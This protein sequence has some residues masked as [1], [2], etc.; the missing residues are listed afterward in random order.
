MNAEHAAALARVWPEVAARLAGML[1][2]RGVDRATAEDIVQ[3]TALR[4]L[5]TSVHFTDAEDLL[6]W[7][8][9]VGFRLARD[10]KL[11]ASR[12]EVVPSPE[13]PS[14]VTVDHEV[15]Q[16]LRLEAAIRGLE[17]LSPLDRDAILSAVTGFTPSSRQESMRLAVRR[18]RAR[19]RLVALMKT[20]LAALLG[21]LGLR[22]PGLKLGRAAL[23]GAAGVP[24]VVTV[25][26]LL[27]GPPEEPPAPPG[28]AVLEAAT[29]ASVPSDTSA[30]HRSAVPSATPSAA[31][32]STSS[33]TVPPPHQS[34]AQDPARPQAPLPSASAEIPGPDGRP[35]RITARPKRPSDEFLCADPLVASYHCTDP[36]LPPLP[37]SP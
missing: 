16:R 33:S 26:L 28:Q 5:R 17:D 36:T 37:G 7:A 30:A 34:P 1:R 19:A 32:S 27:H 22:R 20:G 23:V 12:V 10:A 4:A 6:R 31:P 15:E 24:A 11:K 2:Q 21:L 8:S 3:E 18:H 25:A 14:P 9:V 29:R 13:H 35:G